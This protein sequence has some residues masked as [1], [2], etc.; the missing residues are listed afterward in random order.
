MLTVYVDPHNAIELSFLSDG[1]ANLGMRLFRYQNSLRYFEYMVYG[2]CN[3]LFGSRRHG[4][5]DIRHNN[6]RHN[7]NECDN[8]I[9]N[10]NNR[11]YNGDNSRYV[12]PPTETDGFYVNGTTLYDAKEIL[13]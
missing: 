6:I 12:D 5:N 13:L 3:L 10:C 2:R 1:W 9:G 7:Y 8:N 11:N 4:N